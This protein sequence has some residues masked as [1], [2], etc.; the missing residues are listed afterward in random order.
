MEPPGGTGDDL[1]GHVEAPSVEGG[2]EKRWPMMA[3]S[4]SLG[5]GKR[6][7]LDQHLSTAA[8]R[9]TELAEGPL[10]IDPRL[11]AWARA[12]ASEAPT[13]GFSGLSYQDLAV[14][15]TREGVV[16]EQL[17]RRGVPIEPLRSEW[18]AAATP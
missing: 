10:A 7:P 15:L 18:S 9:W 13:A 17:G 11:S 16:L 14:F 8:G 4:G 2:A 12:L 3:V 5:K 6:R 1:P